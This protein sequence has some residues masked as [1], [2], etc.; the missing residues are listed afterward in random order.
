MSGASVLRPFEILLV[1]DNPGDARLVIEGLR[2]WPVSNHLYIATDGVKA[3]AFLRQEG[4]YEMAPRP[5]VILLDL[6]L[7]R[8]DGRTV[9]REIKEDE[10]LRV[11]PVVVLSTSKADDDIARSYSLHANCYVTK[12]LGLPQFVESLQAIQHFWFTIVTLPSKAT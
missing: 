6:N 12:P 10:S 11:I 1:E 2:E 7:P 3:M 4:E 5:D 9:L 8:K